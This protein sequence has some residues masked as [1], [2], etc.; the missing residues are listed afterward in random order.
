MGHA[1]F[2]NC[3]ITFPCVHVAGNW[4]KLNACAE[5]SNCAVPTRN[6]VEIKLSYHTYWNDG[7]SHDKVKCW[8]G[9][10]RE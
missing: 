7:K 2:L 8:C 5:I 9:W 6:E 4:L 10:R 1:L 3:V